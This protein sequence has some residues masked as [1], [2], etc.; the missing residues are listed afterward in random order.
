MRRRKLRFIGRE[1]MK[2]FDMP[3]K[4]QCRHNTIHLYDET[5]PS[6]LYFKI[7]QTVARAVRF[8]C[9]RRLIIYSKQYFTCIVDRIS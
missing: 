5:V 2:M 6:F 8:I 3:K 4:A 9:N 1:N 7:D